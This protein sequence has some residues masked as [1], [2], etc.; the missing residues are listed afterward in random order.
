MKAYGPDALPLIAGASKREREEGADENEDTKKVEK[1]EEE[2]QKE[3]DDAALPFWD[4][5]RKTSKK[6]GFTKRKKAA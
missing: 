5:L 3:K 2:K 4:R 1:T 6:V